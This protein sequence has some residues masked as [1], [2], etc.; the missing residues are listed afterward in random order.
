[1]NHTLSY[2]SLD[3]L[4][5]AASCSC[6]SGFSITRTDRDTRETVKERLDKLH[7]EHVE[8]NENDHSTVDSLP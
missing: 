7:L 4:Y 3:G 6:G 1:M 2:L 8:Q 5:P